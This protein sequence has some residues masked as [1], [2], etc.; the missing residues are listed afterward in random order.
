MR[1]MAAGPAADAPAKRIAWTLA[2][3]AAIGGGANPVA[4]GLGGVIGES[5]LAEDKSLATLPATAFIVGNAVLAAPAALLMARTGRRFGFVSGS[6]LA[7]AS[8]ALAVAG[9]ALHSF[10]VFCLATAGL[11]AA[12]AFAQQYRFAAADA[13]APTFKPKAI[14]IVLIGGIV[15]GVIGPQA[16][17]VGRN[18]LDL[19]YA[20]TFAIVVA[21]AL[22]SA[23]VLSTLKVPPPPP[24]SADGRSGR[25]L[26]AILLRPQFMVAF[27]CAVASYA[28]MSLVMTAS[29]LAMIH[30][31]HS[32][33]DA[34][35]GIQWHVIA[36]FA[37]SFFTGSLI[38]RFGKE[39][40][41]GAGLALIA[42]GAVVALSGTGVAHFWTS[43][44]LLGVGWNFGFV[45]GTAMVAD[46]YRPEEAAKVQAA[47]E[48]LLFSIVSL[49]SFSS[50]KILT[51][52]G[53]DTINLLVFPVVGGCLVLLAG[54]RFLPRRDVA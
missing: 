13:S 25:P 18:L 46:C 50:G 45:G 12:N 11:G 19:P 20:G 39:A 31:H 14:S 47:N 3:A 21:L 37:P 1:T 41:V 8:A 26:A 15:A 22:A 42:L 24:R 40:V 48:V 43:L 7:A 28:L 53:W 29:P 38:A 51:A 5:L 6:L 34:A 4:I 44:I 9:L 35:L 23:A 52:S 54:M 32:H 16:M 10:L 30:H 36:M 17:I 2:A 27:T 33:G 49:A